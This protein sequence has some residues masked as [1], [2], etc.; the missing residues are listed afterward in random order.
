MIHIYTDGSSRGNP[1][2]GGFGAVVYQ[3]DDTK[4]TAI[5]H[6]Y[7]EQFKHVTN[8]QMELRA[9]LYAF[10]Y[11][12]KYHPN[13]PCIIYSDSAYCVNICNDWIYTWVRN[14]WKNSKKKEVENINYVK[15]LYKYLST[16]FFMCQVNKCKGHKDLIGN[17][18][19]DALATHNSA[20]FEEIILANNIDLSLKLNIDVQLKI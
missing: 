20:K 19:A 12:T 9:I 5:I 14:N 6:C 8:N 7:Q 3:C 2:L 15:A 13:E 17:E 11:A 18:L 1:G 10:E 16:D 4:E